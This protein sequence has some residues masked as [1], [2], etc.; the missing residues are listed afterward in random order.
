LDD[1]VIS[2]VRRNNFRK[3]LHIGTLT[4]SVRGFSE[5][6]NCFDFPSSENQNILAQANGRNSVAL[7][8]GDDFWRLSGKNSM[9][10]TTSSLS[11]QSLLAQTLM[12]FS[13]L[14]ISDKRACDVSAG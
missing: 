13:K 4:Q 5:F 11:C 14:T 6:G 9:L 1:F 3:L 10:E 2:S 7:T 12:A 8:T